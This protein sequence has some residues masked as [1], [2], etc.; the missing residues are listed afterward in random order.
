[1]KLL[2]Y[3]RP[4]EEIKSL[5]NLKFTESKLLPKNRQ[6][7]NSQITQIVCGDQVYITLWIDPIQTIVIENEDVAKEYVDMYEVIWNNSEKLT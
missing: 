7:K 5:G 6:A 3:K 1:M 2:F 4:N